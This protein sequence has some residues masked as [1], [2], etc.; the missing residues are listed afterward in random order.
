MATLDLVLI[1]NLAN[2]TMNEELIRACL[3]HVKGDLERY[4]FTNNLLLRH[5][6]LDGLIMLMKDLRTTA[7]PEETKLKAIARW[8]HEDSLHMQD[9]D[10][11][12]CHFHYLLSLINLKGIP[13]SRI[14]EIVMGQSEFQLSD[15]CR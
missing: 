6:E 15:V 2:A 10:S 13:N 3:P 5:T 11:R 12:E 9:C 1:W 8:I 4:F 14:I 7:I